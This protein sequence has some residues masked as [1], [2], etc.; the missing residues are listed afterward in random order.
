MCLHANRV[1]GSGG[2]QGTGS[3]GQTTPIGRCHEFNH[4]VSVNVFLDVIS[5]ALI[6]CLPSPCSS[7]PIMNISLSIARFTQASWR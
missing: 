4:E 7:L 3:A 5:V 1:L 2:K 6:G